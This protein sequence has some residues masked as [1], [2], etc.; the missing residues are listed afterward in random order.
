PPPLDAGLKISSAMT[1]IMMKAL[2]KKPEDRYQNMTQLLADLNK[3]AK[4][5]SVKPRLLARD[6]KKIR[7][8]LLLPLIFLAAYAAIQLLFTGIETL[9]NSMKQQNAS[10]KTTQKSAGKLKAKDTKKVVPNK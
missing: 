4:G 8:S 1:A 9:N 10:Q 3:L 6:R 2:E 5:V 7:S